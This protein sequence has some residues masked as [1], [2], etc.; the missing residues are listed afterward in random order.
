M[1]HD[2]THLVTSLL[3]FISNLTDDYKNSY[4]H[5]LAALRIGTMDYNNSRE[6]IDTL[7]FVC[8]DKTLSNQCV[9]NVM[10]PLAGLYLGSGDGQVNDREPNLQMLGAA[11]VWL[12]L[13]Y[14]ELFTPYLSVDPVKKVAVKLEILQNKVTTCM[15][16]NYAQ[17]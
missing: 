6:F 13:M 12:G 1:H 17:I 10:K 8:K 15:P 2:F 16:G 3:P 14:M 4:Q 11:W 5:A 9:A 7:T